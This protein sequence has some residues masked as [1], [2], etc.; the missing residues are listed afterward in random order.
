M[1]FFSW[2]FG[3]PED[4]ESLICIRP[5]DR[6]SV[7]LALCRRSVMLGPIPERSRSGQGQGGRNG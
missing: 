7:M 3:G 2:L 5:S 6:L 1:G 4:R